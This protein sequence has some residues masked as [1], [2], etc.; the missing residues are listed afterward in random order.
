MSDES[1]ESDDPPGLF[2]ETPGMIW[3]CR[4]CGKR[5]RTRSGWARDNKSAA[6]DYDWDVSCM[7]NSELVPDGR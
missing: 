3:V 5:S 2:D 6:I 7:L 1:D 4:R